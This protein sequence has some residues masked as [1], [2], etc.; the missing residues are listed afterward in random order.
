MF[1]SISLKRIQK[2][3]LHFSVAF[4]YQNLDG[5]KTPFI[6]FSNRLNRK[7]RLLHHCQL[8]PAHHRHQQYARRRQ[9]LPTRQGRVSHR[10]SPPSVAGFNSND[11]GKKSGGK[12]R[13]NNNTLKLSTWTLRWLD[14]DLPCGENNTL[15]S[16]RPPLL[17]LLLLSV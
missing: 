15:L 3:Y 8:D 6:F 9:E 17:S 7:L 11:R 12:Q 13:N 10:C 16:L 5:E 1:Y 4:Y 14:L 2:I